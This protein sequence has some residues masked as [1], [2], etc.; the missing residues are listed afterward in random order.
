MTNGE[1][2]FPRGMGSNAGV[3]RKGREVGGKIGN[4]E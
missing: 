1:E 4:V 3:T 2:T